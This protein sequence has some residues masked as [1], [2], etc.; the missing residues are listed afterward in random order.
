M[1]NFL[2]GVIENNTTRRGLALG[3][4]SSSLFAVGCGQKSVDV[5]NSH[6]GSKNNNTTTTNKHSSPKKKTELD[7]CNPHQAEQFIEDRMH[8]HKPFKANH[9]V[10]INGDYTPVY[11][12]NKLNDVIQPDPFVLVCRENGKMAVKATATVQFTHKN[13][14][15]KRRVEDFP[16]QATPIGDEVVVNTDPNKRE[17][18]IQQDVVQFGSLGIK[19]S[20]ANAFL[21]Q[22]SKNQK[23]AM[24]VFIGQKS[25]LS[26]I[27]EYEDPL[28][29]KTIKINNAK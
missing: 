1:S 3:L 17:V 23:A 22:T 15:E 21:Y 5:G 20:N 28:D 25:D 24:G 29:M 11:A 18:M 13:A 12:I 9:F 4:V 14:V 16:V 7:G 6:A 26:S 19:N 8:D 27:V 10:M 2:R